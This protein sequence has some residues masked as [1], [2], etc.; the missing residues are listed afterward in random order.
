MS[1][2]SQKV[3][4]IVLVSIFATLW[5]ASM[6]TLGIA[7]FSEGTTLKIET[8]YTETFTDEEAVL[9]GEEEEKVLDLLNVGKWATIISTTALLVVLLFK[10]LKKKYNSK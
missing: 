5:V 9:M 1:K 8:W 6:V 3:W 10:E 4:F 2:K 7:A